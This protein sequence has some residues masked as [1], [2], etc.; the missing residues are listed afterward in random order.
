M[1]ARA[2]RA[3]DVALERNAESADAAEEVDE[4]NPAVRRGPTRTKRGRLFTEG[5]WS[6][7]LRAFSF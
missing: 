3:G 7:A 1:L 2:E 6:L 5:F 4:A